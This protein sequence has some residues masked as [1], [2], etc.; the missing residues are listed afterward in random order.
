MIQERRVY[1]NEPMLERENFESF[2]S[3]KLEALNIQ[4]KAIIKGDAPYTTSAEYAC[5]HC[6]G[7]IKVHSQGH[8][9]CLLCQ[10]PHLW[11]RELK[12]A[13]SRILENYPSYEENKKEWGDNPSRDLV[14]EAKQGL[15]QKIRQAR[16]ALGLTQQ[17]LANKIFKLHDSERNIT[18]KSINDYE[19]GRTQPTK[20]IIG[21]LEQVLS[22]ELKTDLP[23]VDDSALK[24][25][26]KIRRYRN[27]RNWTR[28]DLAARI[29]KKDGKPLSPYTIKAYE[30]GSLQPKPYI[31]EQINKVLGLEGQE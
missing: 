21:Q 28:D 3:R 10:M 7:R 29:M 26:E 24:L 9:Y 27:M 17:G 1:T 18:Q 30:S 31:L 6:S 14:K 4:L 2:Y 8:I 19:Y 20:Y 16:I 12:L 11:T 13:V 23:E 5:C 22:I 15:G 25:G